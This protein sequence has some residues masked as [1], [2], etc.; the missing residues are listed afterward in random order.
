M[1]DKLVGFIRFLYEL[2]KLLILGKVLIYLKQIGDVWTC[3][4]TN[5]AKICTAKTN[6]KVVKKFVGTN[7]FVFFKVLICEN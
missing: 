7:F 1:R 2:I 6:V 3:G 4:N 5:I